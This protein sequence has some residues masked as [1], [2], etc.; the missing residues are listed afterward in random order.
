MN[1]DKQRMW[2]ALLFG[3]A[4]MAVLLGFALRSNAKSD[5]DDAQRANAYRV[6]LGVEPKDDEPDY[7]ASNF[8]FAV[9]G[10]SVLSGVVVVAT[11]PG[12]EEEPPPEG[13]GSAGTATHP[14]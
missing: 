6:A 9:A 2:G 14:G 13:G 10:I 3:V 4:I 12:R 5:A 11:A 1:G 7:F 8:L